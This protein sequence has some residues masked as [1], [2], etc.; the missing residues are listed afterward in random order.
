MYGK[1]QNFPLSPSYIVDFKVI[2]MDTHSYIQNLVSH[3][4][5]IREQ[6]KANTLVAQKKMETIENENI[7]ELKLSVGNY[8]YFTREPVGQGRKFQHTFDRP[9]VVNNIPSPHMILLRD[10]TGKRT[11]RRPVH[12]NR[13]KLAH[14]RAPWPVSYFNKLIGDSS[15]NDQESKSE[16][17]NTSGRD[18]EYDNED[19]LS[20]HTLSNSEIYTDS[21][22]EKCTE[23]SNRPQRQIKNQCV[24]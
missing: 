9:F 22:P 12:V 18:S 13:L 21:V 19:L 6:V 2:P 5:V 4:T 24:T 8:M 16:P 23:K 3:L 17:N 20:K 15:H 1:R 14:L 11:F 10:P 7:H